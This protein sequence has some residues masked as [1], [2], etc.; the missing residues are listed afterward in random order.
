MSGKKLTRLFLV[1]LLFCLAAVNAVFSAGRTTP[2]RMP[3]SAL[4]HDMFHDTLVTDEQITASSFD[5]LHPPPQAR[6]SGTGWCSANTCNTQQIDEYLQINFGAELVVEAIAVTSNSEGFYVTQYML[7]YAG[8]DGMYEYVIAEASSNVLFDGVNACGQTNLEMKHFKY[9]VIA[10]YI[11]IVPLEWVGQSAC[12]KLEL[13]GCQVK[14]CTDIQAV[15]DNRTLL[16]TANVSLSSALNN[17]RDISTN[18]CGSSFDQSPRFYLSFTQPVHLLY[19]TANGDGVDYIRSFF[20]V[21]ENQTGDMIRYSN[22]DGLQS[23]TLLNA[24]DVETYLLWRPITTRRLGFIAN[25]V[26]TT[27]PCIEIHFYGCTH[28]D[29]VLH[30][31][32]TG[33]STS[34]TTV[35]PAPTVATVYSSSS[36]FSQLATVTTTVT[37]TTSPEPS[38][39]C[40]DQQ[41][42]SSSSSSNDSDDVVTICVPVVIVVG[43]IIVIVLVIVGGVVW[44]KTRSDSTQNFDAIVYKPSTTAVVNND[45]YGLES[46]VGSNSNRD[47]HL[48][49]RNGT[50]DVSKR[51]TKETEH[52]QEL[53]P[54]VTYDTVSLH[55]ESP[56]D[57]QSVVGVANSIYEE[58]PTNTHVGLPNPSYETQLPRKIDHA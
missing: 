18:W 40:S 56:R 4:D 26:L 24:N 21:Y 45:L 25:Q 27:Y 44:W 22:V 51:D 46:T 16:P 8:S 13:Y 11:R 7:E 34:E 38:C 55:E 14:E 33:I 20:F 12:L 39:N 35:N 19:V 49:K 3:T 50:V 41:Q 43:I 32:I 47:N 42:S 2:C 5:Q 10:H 52:P 57:K 15:S 17:Y 31:V 53:Q 36:L 6:L 28:N 54:P 58:V 29:L 48:V 9:P 30:P 1:W 37:I 23:F